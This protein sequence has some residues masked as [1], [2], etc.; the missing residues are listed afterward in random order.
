[1]YRYKG[2][3]LIIFEYFSI[4]NI[5]CSIVQKLI[6]YYLCIKKNRMVFLIYKYFKRIYQV[7]LD[8]SCLIYCLKGQEWL[9]D[10][11]VIKILELR[12]LICIEM[13]C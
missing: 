5:I 12:L 13:N 6:Q 11:R 3:V 10:Y 1:M 2:I 4:Y 8:V 9:L 7:N